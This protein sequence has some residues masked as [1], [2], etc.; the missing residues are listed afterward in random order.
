[1]EEYLGLPPLFITS[2]ELLL[3]ANALVFGQ[4]NKVNMLVFILIGIFA[5]NNL[6]EFVS[7]QFKLND[8]ILLAINFSMISFIPPLSLLLVLKFWRHDSKL[9]YLIFLPSVVLVYYF[10]NLVDSFNVTECHLLY[11]TY[12]YPLRFELGLLYFLMIMAALALLLVK[13]REPKLRYKRHL[14][15]SLIVTLGVAVAFPMLLLIL[16]PSLNIYAESI[17]NKFAFFYVLGLTYFSLKNKLEFL[18]E[19]G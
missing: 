13:L 8:R 5:V 11:I 10:I 17:L 2:L 19:K 16:F 1:M 15:I 18:S 9:K 6:I 3:L 4:K 12:S 14:N 7:C